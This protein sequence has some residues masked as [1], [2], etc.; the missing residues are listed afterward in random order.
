MKQFKTI[1]TTKKGSFDVTITVERK[2][3]PI[4]GIAFWSYAAKIIIDGKLIASQ[5]SLVA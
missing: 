3:S 1:A 4:Q 5:I 2:I